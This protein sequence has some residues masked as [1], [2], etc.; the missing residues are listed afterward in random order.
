M[1]VEARD[2]LAH[3]EEKSRAQSISTARFIGSRE[4]SQYQRPS[5]GFRGPPMKGPPNGSAAALA[6]RSN[7]LIEGARPV[8]CLR[9]AF[10]F[11]AAVSRHFGDERTL[12]SL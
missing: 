2:P 11:A 6:S 9:N 5:A 12:A 7:R 3:V 8:S 4:Q 1:N 10:T